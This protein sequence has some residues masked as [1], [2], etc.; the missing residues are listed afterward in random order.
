VNAKLIFVVNADLRIMVSKTLMADR[1]RI[2][3]GK[4]AA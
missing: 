3:P 1:K 4:S 2:D